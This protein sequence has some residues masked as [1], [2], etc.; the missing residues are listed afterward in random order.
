[1]VRFISKKTAIFFPYFVVSVFAVFKV[2]F[3]DNVIVTVL[4]VKVK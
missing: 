4:F 2:L 1:M 3:P